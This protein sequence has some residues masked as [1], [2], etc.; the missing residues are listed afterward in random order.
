MEETQIDGVTYLKL[1]SDKDNYN[2][3]NIIEYL[4]K[5]IMSVIKLAQ[6][7]NASIINATTNYWN[8]AHRIYAGLNL[9][10]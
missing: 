4:K 5:Y 10:F 2:S 1:L 6:D 8:G 3:N 7:V 9:A